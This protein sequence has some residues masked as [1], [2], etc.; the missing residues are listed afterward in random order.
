MDEYTPASYNDPA[1]TAAALGVFERAL[2]K[3]NV[4][5]LKPEMIGE[6]FGVF[7]RHLKVPGLQFRVGSIS[8]QAF[9]A[10]RRPDGPELPPLHSSKFAPLPEP[11]IRTSVRA[12]ANLAVSLLESR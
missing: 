5:A 6:D 12:M 4:V 7:A 3:Q 9:E 10:S 1:L 8:R 2:G 11:T